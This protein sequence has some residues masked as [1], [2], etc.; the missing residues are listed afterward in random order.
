MI[1]T[2]N[3]AEAID[4]RRILMVTI[5]AAAVLMVFLIL[6]SMQQLWDNSCTHA[7]SGPTEVYTPGT[8]EVEAILPEGTCIRAEA[9]VGDAWQE[10]E[11]LRGG[12][13]RTG[14]VRSDTLVLRSP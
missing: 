7:V 10:I 8:S 13:C 6:C 14:F 4:M 3:A 5:P 12:Q 2:Y 11:Y 1:V 9:T